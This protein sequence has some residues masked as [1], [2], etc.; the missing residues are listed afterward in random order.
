MYF[1]KQTN[2]IGTY[3]SWSTQLAAGIL[4]MACCRRI[5]EKVQEPSDGLSAPGQFHI[6]L[7]A[8]SR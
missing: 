2:E 3:L 6:V 7:K 4:L 8:G 5:N 1:L